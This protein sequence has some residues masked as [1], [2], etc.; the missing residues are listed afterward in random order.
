MEVVIPLEATGRAYRAIAF[1]RGIV[2]DE[3]AISGR[4]I[5]GD[6]LDMVLIELMRRSG[7]RQT[8]IR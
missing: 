2:R 5:A 4:S 6:G 7:N 8:I 3:E 1:D